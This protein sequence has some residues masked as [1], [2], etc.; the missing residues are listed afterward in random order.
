MQNNR[1]LDPFALLHH[2]LVHD[3]SNKHLLDQGK[4]PIYTAGPSAR[5]AVIGQAP[6]RRAQASG[7][8]WDDA[9]GATLVEWLGVT[10]EQFRNPNL[11]TLLPM[12][13]YYPGPH[14]SGSGDAPPRRGFAARWH[15]PLLALMPEVRLTLLIGRYAQHAYLPSSRA[16][17]LTDTVRDYQ[18]FLPEQFPLVH[19]S[20]LNFRWHTRNPWFL[21]D[22]VGDLRGQIADALH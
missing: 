18:R 6:G 8:P 4:A 7:I 11:F 13:F 9:S 17:R 19:P 14:R 15:P 10:E 20:P 2:D 12:D 3:E 22:V 16:T 1:N 5:V 21:T